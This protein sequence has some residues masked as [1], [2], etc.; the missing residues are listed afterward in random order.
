[1]ADVKDGPHDVWLQPKVKSLH[2]IYVCSEV[3][4][5]RFGILHKINTNEIV[6]NINIIV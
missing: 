1:M 3:L 5:S 2:F 6:L 4:R